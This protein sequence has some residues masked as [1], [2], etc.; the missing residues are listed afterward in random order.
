VQIS[1]GGEDPIGDSFSLRDAI[2]A[3]LASKPPVQGSE[4]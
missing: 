3:A 4:A 1:Y 2:D